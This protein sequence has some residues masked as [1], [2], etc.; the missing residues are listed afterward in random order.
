MKNMAFVLSVLLAISS[1]PVMANSDPYALMLPVVT[2]ELTPGKV[3]PKTVDK[4]NL[5]R[6]IFIVGDDPL[7]YRWLKARHKKLKALNAMGI[8]VNVHG[9]AGLNRLRQYQLPVYP[10]RGNDFAKAFGLKHYP[11]LINNGKVTQ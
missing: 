3:I 8:V 6:P 4:A 9:V 1:L 7:S 10:V 11:V 5:S 2:P